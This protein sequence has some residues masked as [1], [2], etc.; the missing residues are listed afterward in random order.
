MFA[1]IDCNNF[2]ASCER[3]FDP[4][5]VG[6]P[7]VVLSNN[8]GCVI[9]RSEESKRLGIPMGAPAFQ[10]QEIFDKHGVEIF[11]AN[12]PLYGDM[13]RRVM[14]ILS[15][16]SPV[17]EIYSIDECFLDLNGIDE[18]LSQYGLKM[19]K[20]V[21]LFTGLPISVGIAPTKT[22]AK[23]ANRIA[24]K[25]PKQTGG[26][27]VIDSDELRLKALKWLDVGD[28]WG[29]GRR[30]VAKLNKIGVYKAADFV[31]LPE[32]WVLNNMTVVG[33]NLQMELKGLPAIEMERE[34]KHKSISTTRTFETEYQTFDQLKERIVTFTTLC[35]NKIA[36]SKFAL[37]TYVAFY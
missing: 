20:Q 22:L 13:S 35:A 7:I 37:Q 16:Y 18:D 33:L 11:S 34:E 8:D 5:L 4:K 32:S 3:N 25:Y 2:Y 6:K 29:I 15:K 31:K 36:P 28:V 1:L 26:V 10:C 30:S 19:K 14:N 12:F 27:H 17:Q 24:K 23:V 9:A 21:D